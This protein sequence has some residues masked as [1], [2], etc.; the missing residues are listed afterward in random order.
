MI[1]PGHFLNEG[2]LIFTYNQFLLGY[3]MS[4]YEETDN[5]G[6][7][8]IEW[9]INFNEMVAVPCVKKARLQFHS[10]SLM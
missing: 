10:C 9:K 1:L 5:G 2:F 3:F 6:R 7:I 8:P 4:I